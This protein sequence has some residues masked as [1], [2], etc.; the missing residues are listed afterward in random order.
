MNGPQ[1][2][3]PPLLAAALLASAYAGLSGPAE[4]LSPSRPTSLPEIGNRVFFDFDSAALR[5]DAAETVKKVAEWLKPYPELLIMVEGYTDKREP[6]DH[7]FAL[8]CRRARAARE[9]LIERGIAAERLGTFSYGEHR[10]AALGDNEA[11]RA[12]NRRAEFE[13]VDAIYASNCPAAA[14][15]R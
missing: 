11:A 3:L 6:N 9:A 10:P 4:A 14:P 1:I 15:A 2:L 5:S 7:S 13:A 12:Q 8:G